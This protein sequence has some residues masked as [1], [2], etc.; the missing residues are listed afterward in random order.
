VFLPLDDPRVVAHPGEVPA[1]PF[2]ARE[3]ASWLGIHVNTLKRIP[4]DEL[5]YFR[6]GHRGDRRYYLE[7]VRTYVV[8][9]T[10]R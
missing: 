10:T 3:V 7:D 1:V 5:P 2:T 8:T 6:V 4:K 9:T